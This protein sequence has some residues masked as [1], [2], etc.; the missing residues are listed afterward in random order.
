MAGALR[1]ALT[2]VL[3]LVGLVAVAV[4]AW[5]ITPAAGLIV[6]GTLA[7]LVGFLMSLPP[8]RQ[9]EDA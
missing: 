2:T 5:L 3:E 9:G 6:G 7:V 1:E 4:G 8:R